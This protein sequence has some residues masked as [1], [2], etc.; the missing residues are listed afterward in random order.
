MPPLKVSIPALLS[1][2]FP[3]IN[4]DPDSQ[5]SHSSTNPPDEPNNENENENEN[6]I[7]F[8]IIH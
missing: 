2:P 1:F 3:E 4:N 8:A 7:Y 5:L 6:E